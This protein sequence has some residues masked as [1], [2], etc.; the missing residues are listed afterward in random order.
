MF[1]GV[2]NIYLS[3]SSKNQFSD[4]LEAP[5][6]SSS[7]FIFKVEPSATPAASLTIFITDGS[8]SINIREKPTIYSGKVGTA[9]DGETFTY[10]S[11]DNGWYQ[12]NLASG[13]GYV[14]AKYVKEVTK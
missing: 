1:L 7:P 3:Q 13:S 6:P 4:S 10:I 2:R 9:S 11:K 5:N 14:S 8:P 12:I